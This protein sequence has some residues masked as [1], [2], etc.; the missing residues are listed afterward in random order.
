MSI[1]SKLSNPYNT[2]NRK[3]DDFEPISFS[4]YSNPAPISESI[5]M[6]YL[7]EWE[8]HAHLKVTFWAGPE[9]META[10]LNAKKAVGAAMYAEELAQ[11]SK[12]KMAIMNGDGHAAMSL[13]ELLEKAMTYG[14]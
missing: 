12:L 11:L 14:N 9:S 2:G 1:W 4:L 8:M 10:Q 3:L 7:Q 5:K 6:R 13:V